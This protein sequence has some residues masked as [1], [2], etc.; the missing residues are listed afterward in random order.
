MGILIYPFKNAYTV[1]IFCSFMS[2]NIDI[3]LL[4]NFFQLTQVSMPNQH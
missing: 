4:K 1:Q 3:Y 2:V